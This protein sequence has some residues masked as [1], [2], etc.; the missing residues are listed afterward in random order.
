[1][2]LVAS[3]SGA[4]TSSRMISIQRLGF[5]DPGDIGGELPPVHRQGLARR[6]PGSQGCGHNQG[7]KP[8]HLLLE[9]PHGALAALSPERVAAHQLPQQ[10]RLVGRREFLGLHLIETDPDPPAGR[11]PGRL[12][13]RQ[14]PADDGE[15]GFSVFGFRFSVV[16]LGLGRLLLAPSANQETSPYF[17]PLS[18]GDGQKAFGPFISEMAGQP[19][20]AT[21]MASDIFYRKPKTRNPEPIHSAAAAVS[22]KLHSSRG[23]RIFLPFFMSQGCWHWGQGRSWGGWFMVKAHLG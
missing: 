11:L 15:A 21:S 6:H 16:I 20:C 7:I 14:P 2:M 12:T 13:P 17:N 4:A 1:M 10:R 3:G 18:R 8:P 5:Q 19:Q 23:Q 22:S 9:Q